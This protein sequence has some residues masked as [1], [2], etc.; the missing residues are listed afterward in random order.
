[1]GERKRKIVNN[2]KKILKDK[3]GGETGPWVRGGRD[4][5]YC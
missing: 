4:R 3:V 2:I 1:M 5:I